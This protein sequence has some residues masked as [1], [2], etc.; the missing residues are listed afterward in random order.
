LVQ[1]SG[2]TCFECI[3]LGALSAKSALAFAKDDTPFEKC[4]PVPCRL[5]YGEDISLVI[6]EEAQQYERWRSECLKHQ[7]VAVDVEMD[8]GGECVL[9][10]L[11]RAHIRALQAFVLF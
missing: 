6:L 4:S 3:S 5:Q 1:P 11:I 2:N 8:A 10:G 7:I 9:D